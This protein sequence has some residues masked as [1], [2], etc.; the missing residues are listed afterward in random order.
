MNVM[1]SDML[2]PAVPWIEKIARPIIVYVFLIGMLRIAGKRLLA[3]LNP[4]DFVVLLILS[5]TVQNA[6]IGNDNSVSGAFVGAVTLFA[7]NAVFV[8]ILTRHQG[9]EARV[10]GKSVPLIVASVPQDQVLRR[11]AISGAEL[12]IAAHKQGFESLDEIE[13]ADLYPDGVI[14]FR[15]RQATDDH[16]QHQDLVSRLERIERQLENLT[17]G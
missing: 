1:W 5:N 12:R 16:A 6:I 7:I 14:W 13:S 10:E 3:Q 4:F 9:V 17:R 11:L 2:V 15:R 8:R